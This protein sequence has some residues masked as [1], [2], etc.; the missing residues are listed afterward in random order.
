MSYDD[1]KT[2]PPDYYDPDLPE[3]LTIL[4]DAMTY[5]KPRADDMDNEADSEAYDILADAKQRVINKYEARNE[6]PYD[7][8]EEYRGER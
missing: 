8:W 3:E 4:E 2:T 5:L 7:T 1:W 6:P